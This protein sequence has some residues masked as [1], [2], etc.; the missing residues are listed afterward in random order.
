MI[1]PLHIYSDPKD[2]KPRRPIKTVNTKKTMQRDNE[3]ILVEESHAQMLDI[4]RMVK[5]YSVGEIQQQA[6]AFEGVYG[7]FDDIDYQTA[8]T[9]I[10]KADEIFNQ[11]PSE[12]RQQFNNSAGQFI[13]FVTNPQITNEQLLEKGLVKKVTPT[14]EAPIEVI[15]KNQE[16]TT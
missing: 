9:K 6:T 15:V 1:K 4:N 16:Q 2:L 14:P 7:D 13:D 12:I 8:L 10:A 11:I 5:K 3:F